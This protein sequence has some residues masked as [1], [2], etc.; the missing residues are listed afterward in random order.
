MGQL[1]KSRGIRLDWFADQ[2]GV[3]GASITRWSK[4]SRTMDRTTAERAAQI[5]NLPFF[6]LF[7]S[8]KGNSSDPIS[9]S[10]RAAS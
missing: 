7:E 6:M 8:P 4:G 10:E 1:L 2:L 5:L 3:S 9:N